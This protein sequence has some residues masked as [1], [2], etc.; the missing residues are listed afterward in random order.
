MA[1]V[2]LTQ[3]TGY[4]AGQAMLWLLAVVAV[5]SSALRWAATR[6]RR[7]APPAADAS[8]RPL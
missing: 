6:Q 7:D 8:A 4:P 2:L 3:K 1:G 5:A